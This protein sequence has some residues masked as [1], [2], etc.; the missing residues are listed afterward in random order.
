MLALMISGIV[1]PSQGNWAGLMI[2]WKLVIRRG[3]VCTYDKW[4]I[5]D[6]VSNFCH[7]TRTT[8]RFGE[9]GLVVCYHLCACFRAKETYLLTLSLLDAESVTKLVLFMCECTCVM[10]LRL[11]ITFYHF[12]VSRSSTV[13]ST[14]DLIEESPTFFQLDSRIPSSQSI[15]LVLQPL[16]Q[17]SV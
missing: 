7:D 3:E 5:F 16:L 17:L 15:V 1:E 12:C 11:H 10:P 14:C 6:R 13:P 8:L 4:S 9:S 2:A